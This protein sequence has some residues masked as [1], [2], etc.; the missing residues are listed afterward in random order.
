MKEKVLGG[1]VI[2]SN[3]IKDISHP[4]FYWIK[5]SQNLEIPILP[6]KRDKLLFANGEFE[7]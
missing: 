4:G 1:E 7:G 5:F 2:E 3:I 6:I